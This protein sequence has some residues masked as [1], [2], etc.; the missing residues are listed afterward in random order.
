[1][2]AI[3]GRGDRWIAADAVS[4]LLTT[5]EAAGLRVP[6][7]A[8]GGESM[9]EASLFSSAAGVMEP[10]SIAQSHAPAALASA[11]LLPTNDARLKSPSKYSSQPLHHG[12]SPAT[13][14]HR[15]LRL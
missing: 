1:M 6:V 12:R 11:E 13:P 10:S 5:G 9:C 4:A 2:V 7:Q 8:T 15:R 3:W 14:P